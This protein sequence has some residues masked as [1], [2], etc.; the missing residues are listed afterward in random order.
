MAQRYLLNFTILSYNMA[1][2]QENPFK[3]KWNSIVFNTIFIWRILSFLRYLNFS[4]P[5]E[6]KRLFI[7]MENKNKNITNFLP[8]KTHPH[9]Q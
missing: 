5:K 2:S 9:R 3:V 4:F 8:L 1:E 6:H 7:S